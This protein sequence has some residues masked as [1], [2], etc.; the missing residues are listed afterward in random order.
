MQERFAKTWNAVGHRLAGP[1]SVP[2]QPNS[3]SSVKVTPPLAPVI[4]DSA[5]QEA[6]TYAAVELPITPAYS[7]PVAP[8]V[9]PY[10]PHWET[11]V[12]TY[13]GEGAY[14]HGLAQMQRQGW[15]AGNTAVTQPRSGCLRF[16]MLGGIGALVFKPKQHFI[17]SY[18]RYQ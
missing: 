10:R 4:Q 5:T 8:Y 1:P 14:Q 7:A 15:Q 2:V 11:R 16:L 17:V 12:V 9:A 18:Q 6:P 3:E 13:T